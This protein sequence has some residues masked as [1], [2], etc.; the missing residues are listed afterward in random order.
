MFHVGMLLLMGNYFLKKEFTKKGFTFLL[1]MGERE[2]ERES[3]KNTMTK[4]RF[5][6]LIALPIVLGPASVLPLVVPCFLHHLGPITHIIMSVNMRERDRGRVD[7]LVITRSLERVLG[8]RAP[9]IFA[10]EDGEVFDRVISGS[11]SAG[12]KFTAITL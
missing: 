1:N 7:H 8:Q 4:T 3:L 6:T 12:R 9:I 11:W 2:R 5:Y 10:P